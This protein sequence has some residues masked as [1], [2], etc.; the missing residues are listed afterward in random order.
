LAIARPR[1][2]TLCG[3]RICVHA[4][5]CDCI[6]PAGSGSPAE[7]T[8][9]NRGSITWLTPVP[10]QVGNSIAFSLNISDLLSFLLQRQPM[11]SANTHTFVIIQICK[12]N[13]LNKDSSYPRFLP[14][15]PMRC[16]C[17]PPRLRRLSASRI[18]QILMPSLQPPSLYLG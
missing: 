2:P 15:L 9:Q 6:V 5:I 8:S 1:R 17:T 14:V 13:A 18:G 11:L 3:F 4:R 10:T 12:R 16:R 7:L